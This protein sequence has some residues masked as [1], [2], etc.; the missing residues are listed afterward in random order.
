MYEYEVWGN[1][2]INV[3]VRFYNA[4]G[5][6]FGIWTDDTDRLPDG[7]EEEA[8]A[9]D[10]LNWEVEN[11]TGLRDAGFSRKEVIKNV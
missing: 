3:L 7:P 5:E 2:K 6:T 1:G 11:M 4:N 9:I 10:D 8:N